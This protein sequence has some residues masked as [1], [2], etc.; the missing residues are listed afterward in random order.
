MLLLLC[1]LFALPAHARDQG[2]DVRPTDIRGLQ[3]G[4]GG[5]TFDLVLEVE[6]TRG[7]AVRL[8]SLTYDLAV[9]G[10]SITAD[11]RDL[12]GVKL[13]RGIPTEVVIPVQ[14]GARDA[15]GMLG[16]ALNQ[17]DLDVKLTGTAK[18]RVLLVPFSVDID[19]TLAGR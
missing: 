15:L 2:V 14:I 8:R 12:D 5:A 3:V 19:A 18:V 11:E 1:A 6:R 13:K 4:L 7:V 10:R 9:N 16:S 17:G